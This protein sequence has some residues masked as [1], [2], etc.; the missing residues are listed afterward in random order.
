M[1]K[2]TL[3]NLGEKWAWEANSKEEATETYLKEF[4]END[5]T[6]EKYEAYC[7]SLNINPVLNWT[8]VKHE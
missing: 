8:E 7:K 5:A 2:Y 3:N 4:M 6:I 1:N